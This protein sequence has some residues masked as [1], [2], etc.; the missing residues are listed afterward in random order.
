MTFSDY[1][2][3][4]TQR[5]EEE[6]GAIIYFVDSRGYYLKKIDLFIGLEDQDV[7]DYL[8][9]DEFDPLY[10][11]YVSPQI[12]LQNKTT[13][14]WSSIAIMGDT[15]SGT[16]DL[17]AILNNSGELFEVYFERPSTDIFMCDD[18]VRDFGDIEDKELLDE[19]LQDIAFTL[20]NHYDDAKF[21][22]QFKNIYVSV[23]YSL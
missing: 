7:A 18:L 4:E 5:L 2:I 13:G 23:H 11:V 12:T 20:I 21:M 8:E 10:P 6:I 15:Y 1:K 19:M 17:N 16:N 22:S 3:A 14:E 9:G